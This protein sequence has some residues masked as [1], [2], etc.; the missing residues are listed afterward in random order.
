MKREIVGPFEI[1]TNS[2]GNLCELKY[3]GKHIA[4]FGAEKLDDLRRV[5]DA[6]EGKTVYGI[7]YDEWT[8]G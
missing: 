1:S 6:I 4:T 7:N 3:M 2:L 5:I 8:P